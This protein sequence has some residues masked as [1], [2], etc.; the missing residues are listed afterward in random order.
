MEKINWRKTNY[1]KGEKNMKISIRQLAEHCGVSI[2]TIDRVLNNRPGVKL[3]TREMVEKKVKELGYKPNYLA[4]SLSV[5]KTMSIGVVLFNLHN[6]FFAELS[7]AL[8]KAADSKGYFLYLTLSEKSKQ[9]EYDCVK[10]LVERQVDGIILFSTNRDKDFTEYLLTCGVPIL[11][12][13]SELEG[14]TR[15]G[16][17]DS[18]AMSDATR[19][20]A[21]KHYKRIVYVSAP[22]SYGD[23]M[24][25]HVQQNRYKGYLDVANQLEIESILIDSKDYLNIID[26][27]DLKSKKTAFLC[28]SDVYAL[29]IM[30]HLKLRGFKTPLD[31]GLMGFDNI[32]MLKYIDPQIATVNVPIE[33]VG[34][35][36]VEKL[37][38]LMNTNDK[39]SELINLPYKIIP[40]QTVI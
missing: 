8:V 40:G 12:I 10:N 32:D 25:I 5:G 33:N 11:T 28:S 6:S 38:D 34:T 13:M 16:I 3:Q 2:G 37:L 27:I 31:Y 7:D 20:I 14:F 18:N 35:I 26:T 22:L 21:S 19:F 29:E 39:Q 36:A 15:I 24:N 30:R 23:K 17:D 1:A 4:R 9:K